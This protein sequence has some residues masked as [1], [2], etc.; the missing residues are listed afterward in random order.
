VLK[1]GGEAIGGCEDLSAIVRSGIMK[2]RMIYFIVVLFI[3]SCTTTEKNNEDLVS[4][5]IKTESGFVV[6][7]QISKW[8]LTETSYFKSDGTNIGFKYR[9]EMYDSL[10]GTVYIYPGKKDFTKEEIEMDFKTELQIVLKE[11]IDAKIYLFQ[12]GNIEQNGKVYQN[13][14]AGLEYINDGTKLLSILI[15]VYINEWKL[16]YRISFFPE[17]N[18]IANPEIA[19][20]LGSIIYP[21]L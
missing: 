15:I 1:V 10:T 18:G 13:G 20:L 2:Q 4:K 19:Q 14:V 9:N 17:L 16:K 11:K 3:V 21:S 8:Y 12:L 7:R 5:E 6:K